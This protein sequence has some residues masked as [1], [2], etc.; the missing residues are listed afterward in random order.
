MQESIELDFIGATDLADW[1]TKKAKLPFRQ[2][3]KIAGSLVKKAESK[4]IGLKDLT[5]KEMQKA[6]PAITKDIYKALSQ[7]SML[8]VR[9][10]IG[11]TAP[12]RVLQEANLWA[13][14]LKKEK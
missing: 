12:N 14:R 6:H 5:L 2:A 3:H 13:K 10:H 4:N 11:G 8:E 7:K 9:N 1:L